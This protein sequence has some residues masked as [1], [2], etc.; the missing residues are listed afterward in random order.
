MARLLGRSVPAVQQRLRRR[1]LLGAL[2]NHGEWGF[3]V[4]QFTDR[5]VPEGLPRVLQAFG[6]AD[7]W[8]QLSVLLSYAY[9]EGRVFDWIRE[10]RRLADAE[11]LAASWGV[12]GAA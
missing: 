4:V 7:P 12:Q 8:V 5:G 1:T 9:G 10:D 2:L 11:R 3:P 6:D